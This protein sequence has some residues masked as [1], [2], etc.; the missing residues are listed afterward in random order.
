M[1]MKNIADNKMKA[2]LLTEVGMDM[3]KRIPAKLKDKSFDDIIA[4]VKGYINPKN[5]EA[6]ERCK[7][8]QAKQSPSESIADFNERLKELAFF[9]L[10]LR[11]ELK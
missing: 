6:I 8:Q 2:H 4:F 9:Y 1:E 11:M 10:V 5:N 3:Y 7:F